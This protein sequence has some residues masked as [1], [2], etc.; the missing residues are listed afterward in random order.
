MAVNLFG[1]D[2]ASQ[3]ARIVA[4]PPAEEPSITKSA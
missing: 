1:S 2:A 4:Q 3:Q